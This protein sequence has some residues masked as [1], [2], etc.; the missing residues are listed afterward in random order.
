MSKPDNKRR[1]DG[2][3]GKP[4]CSEN[5][6]SRQRPCATW[7]QQQLE[8]IAHRVGI[9]AFAIG[10][11]KRPER[12]GIVAGQRIAVGLLA[13]KQRG[14]ERLGF[15]GQGAR[16]MSGEKRLDR[17]DR[18]GT[19]GSYKRPLRF[20]PLPGLGFE[21]ASHRFGALFGILLGFAFARFHLGASRRFRLLQTA[22]LGF[23]ALI[24]FRDQPNAP[25]LKAVFIVFN[26]T[27]YVLLA[28]RSRGIATLGDLPGKVL[29]VAEGDLAFRLWPALA[30]QNGVDVASIKIERMSAAVRAPMLSAGQVDATTGLSYGTAVD[31]R[32]RGVPADDLMVFRFA[33]YGCDS[34]GQA[35]IVTPKFASDHP[36]DVA[37][38][39]RALIGGVKFAA[40]DPAKAVDT[41][42]SQMDGGARDLE[43][44]RLHAI[45]HDNILT[46]EVKRDGIGAITP[47]R[48]VSSVQQIAV[49]YTFNRVPAMSDI[50]DASFLPPVV[51]RKIGPEP[52]VR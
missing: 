5:R 50:F 52:G 22:L 46:A 23:D 19:P 44:E 25:R 28:R 2:E 27:P 15:F 12:G 13:H 42:L 47:E 39:I 26:R 51:L 24:R 40:K 21:A 48:F 4:C 10:A 34:Y 17:R 31:V 30:K 29:G 6:W 45:L 1:D 36:N 41:A 11:E 43:L 20:G 7:L 9:V 8:L 35:V 32:D 38:F 37:G 14:L 3:G 18:V 33:D 16:R 49:D